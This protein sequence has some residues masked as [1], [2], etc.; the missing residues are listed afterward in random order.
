MDKG[1]GAGKGGMKAKSA[2]DKKKGATP[3]AGPAT[4]KTAA[5]AANKK[6]GK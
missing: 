5:A 2:P 1:K 4:D 3:V 6:K